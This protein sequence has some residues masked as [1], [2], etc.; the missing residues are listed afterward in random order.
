M[1]R[2]ST[3]LV[4]LTALSM[5][6]WA[7]DAPKLETTVQKFSYMMGYR[8]ARDMAQQ[9][10]RNL[11]ADAL[12]AG[13][14][15]ALSGKEFALE[16]DEI[17]K[18]MAEY[19]AMMQKSRTQEETANAEAGRQFL[20]ENATRDGVQSLDGGVQYKVEREGNGAKPV[21]TDTVRVHYSG[22]LLDG[23]EFDSS[24]E[25]GQPTDLGLG[26]V[27][28]GWRTAL[29]A[30]PVGSK[31]TICIPSEQAYGARGAG[32]RIGPNQTLRFDIELLEVLGPAPETTPQP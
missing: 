31:W 32:A 25:R 20:A 7:E 24:Y 19:Q 16:R 13:I 22:T 5:T 8:L 11:D 15:G 3:A 17:Q 18:V 27:I 4:A 9:G 23:T 21:A 6:A 29:M 26:N 30:M 14:K 12:T 2:F 1:K 28:P 10:I